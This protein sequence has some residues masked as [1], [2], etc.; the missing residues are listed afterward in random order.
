MFTTVGEE[1]IILGVPGVDRSTAVEWVE[2]MQVFGQLECSRVD[3]VSGA[4]ADVGTGVDAVDAGIGGTP[5]GTSKAMLGVVGP[6]GRPEVGVSPPPAMGWGW[7]LS[8]HPHRVGLLY[9]LHQ[10]WDSILRSSPRLHCLRSIIITTLIIFLST[11][12]RS[13]HIQL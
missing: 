6:K 12:L 10:G 5:P 3:A 9:S 7:D 2:W 11:P 1:F 13:P 4:G 8:A